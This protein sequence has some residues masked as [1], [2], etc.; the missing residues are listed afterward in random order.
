MCNLRQQEKK[1]IL[2][3]LQTLLRSRIRICYWD[4]TVV[5]SSFQNSFSFCSIHLL[6]NCFCASFSKYFIF[7]IVRM[8]IYVRVH[9]CVCVHRSKNVY[10]CPWSPEMDSRFSGAAVTSI[11]EHLIAILGNTFSG[12][13]VGTPHWVVLSVY[14]SGPAELSGLYLSQAVGIKERNKIE[15]EIAMGGHL[16]STRISYKNIIQSCYTHQ[17]KGE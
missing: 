12:C 4:W 9:V 15:T 6:I 10:E 17:S 3:K 13:T 14:L 16:V 8:C 7:I 5:T 11:G 2:A 1:T